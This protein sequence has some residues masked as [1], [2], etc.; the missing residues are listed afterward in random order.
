MPDPTVCVGFI[1][2]HFAQLSCAYMCAFYSM[3][4]GTM[5]F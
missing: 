1:L 3:W 2:F 5:L 4:Y